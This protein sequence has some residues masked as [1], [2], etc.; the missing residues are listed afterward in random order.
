MKNI[1]QKAQGSKSKDLTPEQ[2]TP[3]SPRPEIYD[4]IG[5]RLRGYFD[6]V[7][8]QPVPDR[9]VELLKQLD[10]KTPDKRRH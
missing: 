8:S 6:D 1:K 9:F 3:I 7:A 2:S 5:K 10:E 4:L